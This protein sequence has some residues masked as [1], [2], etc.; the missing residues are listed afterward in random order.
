MPV[1][2]RLGDP[3]TDAGTATSAHDFFREIGATL[4]T[5][6]VGAVFTHRLTDQ[7]AT[8]SVAPPPGAV[9]D[10]RSPTPALVHSLPDNVQDAVILSCQ[11]A[12][13]PVFRYLV[14]VVVPGLVP[15]LLPEKELADGNGNGNDVDSDA[16]PDQPAE[17][18]TG[19]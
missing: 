9:G 18:M 1:Y 11:H 14:P 13:T 7:L 17:A 15:T 19:N 4:D 12:L 6:G 8:A 10:T 16:T 2:G 3:G 5:S